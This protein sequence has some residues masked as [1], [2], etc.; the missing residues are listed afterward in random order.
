MIKSPQT[1][2]QNMNPS[3]LWGAATS[4]HQ[5]DGLNEKSDWWKWEAS[6][7]I[8]GGVKSGKAAD[9]WTRFREDIRLAKE[10]GLNSY[11]FSFEWARLERSEGDW[12]S[13]VFD[14]YHE[15]INECERH[16]LVP[17]ATLYH[18]TLPQWLAEQGGLAAEKMP[19]LFATYTQKIAD[20]FAKRIPLWCTINEPMV[21]MLGGYLG[22]RFMPPAVFDPKLA[23]LACFNLLKSH[24][25]AYDILKLALGSCLSGRQ[26]PFRERECEV[27]FAHNMIY[28]QPDR[29]FHPLE[30]LITKLLSGLYNDSWLNAVHGEKQ[31][32][33]IVGVMPL[34]A[35][36]DAARARKTYDF[37]GINYYTKAFVQW[38]PRGHVKDRAAEL[39]LGFS[40]ARRRDVASDLGWAVHPEGLSHFLQR[41][42]RFNAPV[43]VTENGIADASDQRRKGYILSHLQAM[44]RA[45]EAGLDLRG[46]YHWS[47][48]DNFEWIKGFWPRFGLAHVDY[49]TFARTR[50]PSAEFFLEIIRAHQIGGADGRPSSLK[51][52]S[53]EQ[54]T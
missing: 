12:D 7:V 11:R 31:K 33:G 41:L 44:A 4:G 29:P 27:G 13:S 3:F 46:Y 20:S 18:F 38:R 19:R 26:G 2:K 48:I 49:E 24:V 45:G 21:V 9:H 25:L 36:F 32:F 53:F 16:E 1:S 37:I 35:Q 23:S 22:G 51:L 28:L 43:Y 8:D 47:L 15:L 30:I 40:F 6:G 50:R 17:M 54:F 14:W 39:P 34:A 52:H 5:I 42:K 10:M